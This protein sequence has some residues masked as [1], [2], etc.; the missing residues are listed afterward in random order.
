[1][2]KRTLLFLISMLLS[3]NALAQETE[4][5]V[6]SEDE[7][8]ANR[9]AY[10]A[11][12]AAAA[13]AAGFTGSGV[14]VAVVD[15]AT[16]VDH[17]EFSEQFSDLQQ[18]DFNVQDIADHGTPVSSIIAG[19]KDGL[20]MHGVAYNAKIL[21]FAVDLDDEVDCPTCYT[22]LRAW[23]TL[24]GDMYDSVK[25][26]N[27]SFGSVN[28]PSDIS[29]YVNAAKYLVAKDKLIVAPAGNETSLSPNAFPSSLPVQDPTLKNNIISAIAYDPFY[30]VSS[31]YFLASY[32]NLAQG[33][34]EWSL[35][36]P[37]GSL[38]AASSD[39]ATSYGSF[40]GTS[41][42]APMISGA[43]AV[44]SS[45]FPYMG[46]KQLADVLFSTAN[47]NYA[48]FSDYMIQKDNGKSQFLFFG[49]SDGYGREWT[50]TQKNSIV[51]AELGGAY[52]CSSGGVYCV[53]V[54]YSDVF[55]Q[56]IIDLASAIK[57]P[58]YL[59]ANRLSEQTDY[60]NNEYVYTIDV[61]NYDSTWSNNISQRKA[62]ASASTSTNHP[63]ANVGL[64]K[65]GKGTLTL[66]GQNTYLGTT[67]VEEGTLKLT[68]SLAGAVN[69]SAGTFYVNGGTVNNTVSSQA[70]GTIQIDSGTIQSLI[71]AGTTNLSGGSVG[72]VENSSIFYL[73]GTGTIS[74][75]TNA[76]D[77]Y[78]DGGNITN[79]IINTANFYINTGTVNAVIENTGTVYNGATLQQNTVKGGTLV[80]QPGGNLYLTSQPDTLINYGI[81]VLSPDINDPT[82][83]QQIT[84]TDLNLAS[85]KLSIDV[86]N[87]P[88]FG[89]DQSYTILTATNSITISENFESSSNLSPFVTA[90]T[91][92][93]DTAKTVSVSLDYL[94]LSYKGNSPSLTDSER[95]TAATIDNLFK[96]EHYND[97]SGYYFFSEADLKKQINKMNDQVK[98]IHF[99]SLPL[100][101]KLSAGI[102]THLF[103]RQIGK[104]PEQY[105]NT[106]EYYTPRT[107]PSVAS[108]SGAESGAGGVDVYRNYRPGNTPQDDY[109]YSVP[110]RPDVYRNYR[111][112]NTPQDDYHYYVPSR[113]DVYK[114]Y[115]PQGRSGG[116]K[117]A[118][119]NEVWGQI[120]YGK[121]TFEAGEEAQRGDAE[122]SGSG[123][124][125]G[126]DFVHSKD[127]L[128]GLTAGYATTSVEQDSDSMDITDL[129]LGAYFSRQKDFWSVNGALMI[130]FQSYD[131]KRVTELPIKTFESQ[132][133]FDGTSLEATVNVGYDFQQIPM[134][135]GDW[136]FRPYAGLTFTQ[137]N[138][139]AYQETGN[140]DLNL[141]VKKASDTGIMMSA[142]LISGFV[143]A[144][145]QMFMF[146]PEYIFLDLRYDHYLSG[147]SSSTQAYFSSDSLQTMFNSLD[148]EETSLFTIGFGINGQISEN[149]KLNLLFSNTSGSKSSMQNISATVIYSF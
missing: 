145:F 148:S 135:A 73:S 56:G 31:P 74:D 115:R 99:A 107:E 140:S 122:S 67:L 53:D 81:I 41:A 71:N 89:Q 144:P 118:A 14:T 77:F 26:I 85:G 63:E 28:V 100:S 110:S 49:T 51:Q 59:D 65:L 93:D 129:R 90:N 106:K 79:K 109:N 116:N 29:D 57:G 4:T 62:T 39:S 104:T 133:S 97:F 91:T 124:M 134:N 45:A 142:G 13:Y 47:K 87:L 121:G 83:L 123:L 72:S 8:N 88:E 36:A 138:Q 101:N 86:A 9:L 103:E 7:Y 125:F 139:D 96:N 112:G 46:G 132:A 1:M 17:Q 10:D 75:L 76:Q 6:T 19:Q 68:G 30:S 42:A 82:Q 50:D 25:I 3:Q 130:G 15:N 95:Q 43:A 113:P 40:S 108:G 105:Q 55:G 23:Q 80:N 64:K 147:G 24:S 38:T 16:L 61:Q 146:K 33:A 35:T 137:I 126:W 48:A 54:S 114:R 149:I 119:Q 34:Q 136:S 141:S 94:S 44:V 78:F 12:G 2:N 5:P 111:P 60:V 143:S 70:N 58:G 120:L 11:L 66:A 52:S 21:A 37:V 69:V 32:T 22:V 20:G 92:I 27:N 98:P 18:S 102:R 84:V 127:F 128:W 117:F 131:K